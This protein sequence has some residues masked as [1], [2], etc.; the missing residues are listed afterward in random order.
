M[1][2]GHPLHCVQ[3][4]RI[5]PHRIDQDERITR[6]ATY[7]RAGDWIVGIDRVQQSLERSGTKPLEFRGSSIPSVQRNRGDRDSS[8]E[9]CCDLSR[10]S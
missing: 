5:A 9:Q 1:E 4:V 3:L 10:G 8:A 2:Q 6:D 7:M